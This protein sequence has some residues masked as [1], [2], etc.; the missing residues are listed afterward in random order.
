MLGKFGKKL[1][2]AQL[3]SVLHIPGKNL[4]IEKLKNWMHVPDGLVGKGTCQTCPPE[5][6]P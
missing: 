4:K 5:F 3:R 6:R 2:L 1:K